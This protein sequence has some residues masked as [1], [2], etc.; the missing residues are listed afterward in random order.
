MA[1]YDEKILTYCRANVELLQVFMG[2]TMLVN[3]V[4]TSLAMVHQSG[5]M[6]VLGSS[7]WAVHSLRF[8]RPGGLLG[9]A[10]ATAASKVT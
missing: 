6:L 10:V 5:A 1:R 4:P 8:A 9:A 3:E 7:L 2:A